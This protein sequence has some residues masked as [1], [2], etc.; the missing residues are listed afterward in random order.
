M[1]MELVPPLLNVDEAGE[2]LGLGRATAY[3][4]ARNGELPLFSAIGTQ[5]IITAKLETVLGRRITIDEL[6]AARCRLAPKRDKIAAYGK[7]YREKQAGIVAKKA[8]RKS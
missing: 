7:A 6:T 8:A 2:I 3:K 1:E 5:K 4:L